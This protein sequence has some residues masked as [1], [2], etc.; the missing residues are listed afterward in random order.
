VQNHL[1]VSQFFQKFVFSIPGRK[2]GGHDDAADLFCITPCG[3]SLHP[4]TGSYTARI[5]IRFRHTGSS[6][7]QT[8]LVPRFRYI[9]PPRFPVKAPSFTTCLPRRNTCSTA[10]FTRIPS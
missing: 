1:T 4:G 5:F 10:P 7:V 9:P 6:P 2:T 8:A 3:R